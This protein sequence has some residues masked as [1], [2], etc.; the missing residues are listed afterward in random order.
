MVAAL[1]HDSRH[2]Q[3]SIMS[4]IRMSSM[5]HNQKSSRGSL[6]SKFEYGHHGDRQSAIGSSLMQ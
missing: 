1:S 5:E 3:G 2:P 6:R 4:N